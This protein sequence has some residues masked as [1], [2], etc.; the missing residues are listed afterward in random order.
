[1]RKV[2]NIC[3]S[4]LFKRAEHCFRHLVTKSWIVVTQGIVVPGRMGLIM[5]VKCKH[6][7]YKL[8]PKY[9]KIIFSNFAWKT[10]L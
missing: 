9:S 4:M 1:M 2:A 5:L 6:T 3:F 10:I 8:Q 7:V